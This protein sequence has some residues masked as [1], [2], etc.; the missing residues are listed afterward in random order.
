MSFES[1]YNHV[2]P[3]LMVLFRLLGLFVFAPMLSSAIIPARVRVLLAVIL[4]LGVYPT[5]PGAQQQ[6]MELDLFML[7]PAI[8]GETLIGTVI[9]LLAS[10]PMY[11]AQ[12]AGLVMGQQTGMSLGAVFNPALETDADAI[13]QLLMYVAL[14]AFI[15]L[16]GLELLFMGVARSFAH[17]PL[18]RA[19]SLAMPLDLMI[20]IVTSGFELALRVAAPVLCILLVETVV[21]GLLMKTLPQINIMS[22]GYGI[23]I[24]LAL[25]VLIAAMVVIEPVIVTDVRSTLMDIT[26]WIDAPHAAGAPGGR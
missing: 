23:K 10:L 26:S 18:G 14:A 8:A 3:F 4:A 22:L 9:G 15:A 24:L 20:G 25:V 16:G 11:A 12:L 7:A 6:P 1:L 17:V 21:S 2:G 19:W 5:L 13:G